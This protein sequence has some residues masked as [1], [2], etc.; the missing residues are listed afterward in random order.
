MQVGSS[1]SFKK[2]ISVKSC[3]A[4]P[5]GVDHTAIN[6]DAEA[7]GELRFD[8]VSSTQEMKFAANLYVGGSAIAWEGA[9]DGYYMTGY[10][11]HGNC[12]CGSD[13]Q[14]TDDCK[15]TKKLS[16]AAEGT[17][18]IE[19]SKVNTNSRVAFR[20]GANIKFTMS[21]FGY[22]LSK[23]YSNDRLID[24]TASNPAGKFFNPRSWV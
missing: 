2:G 7:Y 3:W 5:F 8:M 18:G 13:N 11:Y 10:T 23:S 21:C 16:V 9:Y 20:V 6:F 15:V 1:G 4:E 17:V 14:V 22:D 24:Q 19:L 12:A